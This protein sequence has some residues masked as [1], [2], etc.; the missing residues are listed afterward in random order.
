MK[1]SGLFLGL[2]VGLLVLLA[3]CGGK[4]ATIADIP[5]YP[6]AVPLEPG[7]DP[8]ADTLVNNMVQDAQVRSSVGA[9][10]QIEQK[11]YRLPAGTTWE[12]VQSFYNDKLGG[13]GWENG[14][15]GIAGN[16]AGDIMN[17]VN[18]GNDMFQTGIWSKDK[19]TLTL[20]RVADSVTGEDSFFLILSLATN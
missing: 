11:A 14:L 13:D 10:G 7:V 16:L 17:S 3:A 12:Q 8:V 6:D 5:A 1:K 4:A 2:L 18:E 9:G 19:Q 20:I 15:G